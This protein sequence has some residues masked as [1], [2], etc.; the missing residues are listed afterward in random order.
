MDVF[1]LHHVHRFND[2]EENAKL[3]GVYSSLV[4]A[5]AAIVRLQSQPGFRELPDA[6]TIS[7]YQLDLDHWTEGY[8]TLDPANEA[9]WTNTPDTTSAF[10][11]SSEDLA[12]ALVQAADGEPDVVEQLLAAGANPSGMPLLMAIQSGEATIIQMMIA[13]GVTINAPFADTT[14]LVRAITASFPDIVELLIHAGADV[15]QIAPDGT[16]PLIAAQTQ[17]RTNVTDDVRQRI[18][19]LLIDAGAHE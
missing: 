17:G 1:V 13:A 8:T 3:I 10:A 14:P 4:T 7:K 11:Q 19:R 12:K 9:S 15:N 2:G 5:R 18:V 6:F 16:V